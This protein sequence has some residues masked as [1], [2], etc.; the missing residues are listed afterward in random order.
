MSKTVRVAPTSRLAA[1]G[2]LL[3]LTLAAATSAQAQI[4]LADIGKNV[5]R[6]Q[7]DG[8][9]TLTGDNAF[10]YAR[11]FFP[12]DAYDGGS[13]TV[14]GTTTYA[15]NSPSFDCCGH[16]TGNQ[17]QTGFTTKAAMD[18]AF[19]TQSNYTT[20]YQVS[21]T[22]STNPGNDTTFNLDLPDDFYSA[23]DPTF[24]AADFSAMTGLTANQGLTLNT[25]GF[26]PGVGADG[27]TS[28]LSVFDLTAGQYVYGNFGS[29][30]GATW[31]IAAGSFTAGH[32]YETQLIYDSFIGLDSDVPANATADLRTD[33]F[34]TA[35]AAAVPEPAAWALMLVG[36][37]AMG[38]SLRRR[39]RALAA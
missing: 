31:S 36:F 35:G 19:P 12:A 34:F 10:F 11:A 17:Y 21:V 18:A 5:E 28:F 29:S 27:G 38:A 25:A 7:T 37:G 2:A 1:A 3:A 30:G 4:T 13:L 15:F 23:N 6:T 32:N 9:G 20:P 24:S 14:N 16:L 33:V 39:R 8:A 26:T 22:S